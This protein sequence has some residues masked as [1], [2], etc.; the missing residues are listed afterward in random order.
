[1]P[2]V[3]DVPQTLKPYLFHLPELSW[4][5]GGKEAIGQCPWCGRES[6]FAVSIET[7]HWRCLVCN[8]GRDSG[9]PI[10]GGGTLVF[11]ETL[12]HLSMQRTTD[13]DLATLATDRKL[14]GPEGLRAW[15]VC[16]SIIDNSWIVAGYGIDGKIRQIYR[17]VWIGK[18]ERWAWLPTPE[19]KHQLFGVPLY[20]SN[21]PEVFL[22]E[23]LWDGIALWET[24]RGCKQTETGK[25]ELVD[26]EELS[27]LSHCNVLATPACSVFLESWLPIFTGKI[28]NLLYDN[29]H[30]KVHPKTG[31]PIAPAGPTYMKEHAMALMAYDKPPKK[32]YYVHWGESGFDLSL[33]SG[34]D[35]RDELTL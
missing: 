25:F 28:V 23:G 8:E 26:R 5:S 21:K 35:V 34:H 15:G 12:Y 13:S 10:K 22:C 33:P 6:K 24:F 29:D 16:R 11:V 4:R 7:G 20:S 31:A 2:E 19:L 18:D 17:W 9:K 30:P 14:L 3:A 27:L 1:M 32:M